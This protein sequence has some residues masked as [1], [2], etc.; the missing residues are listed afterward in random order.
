MEH[1]P[2]LGGLRRPRADSPNAGWRNDSFRGYADYMQTPQFAASLDELLNLARVE[3]VAIMCAEAVPWR[4]HRSLVADA[5]LVRGVAIEHI[6]KPDQPATAQA[7][8]VRE[9]VRHGNS[10]PGRDRPRRADGDALIDEFN[11]MPAQH[12]VP[13]A[14]QVFRQIPLHL[15]SGVIGHRIQMFIKFRQQPH[16]MAFDERRTFDPLFVI[17]ETFLRREAGQPDVNARLLRIACG[18]CQPHFTKFADRRVQ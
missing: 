18:I 10:L 12:R 15:R 4:C 7:D 6:M 9:S 11:S 8:P 17:R 13:R 2:G 16:S 1:L 5:L 14:P 3:T